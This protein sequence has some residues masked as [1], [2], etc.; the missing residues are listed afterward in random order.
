[1]MPDGQPADF[2]QSLQRGLSV[3]NSFS[4]EH[5]HQTLSEVAGRTGLTR[6][7]SR[8][9]LLTLSELGYVNQNG[10]AF[11]LTPKVLDL[12]YSF[13]SSFRVVE[14]AQPS[15]ERL[16]D[17]VH[18]SSSMAVL[19]GGEIV[20]VARVPTSRIMTIA[21]ALGSRLPAYPTSMGRVLLSGLSDDELDEYLLTTTLETLT[22]NTTTSRRALRSIVTKVRTD[23][24]ALVDQEL[25]EGVR[26]IAAPIIN[27]RG[28]VIAAMNV[29]CHASRVD[30]DRMMDEFQPRLLQA[31]AEIS[32]LVR[33]LPV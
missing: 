10:R 25:E 26:S 16:V 12:G 31:A 30:V 22:V 19:D 15:M 28:D 11:S 33:S 5:P 14:V 4:R 17:D 3:I 2:V 6:A 23:G 27:S 9:V 20:Y 8:R 13:L 24:F 18:E 1:M 32:E 7:T 29:S 21:L